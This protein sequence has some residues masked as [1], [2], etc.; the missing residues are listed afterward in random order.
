LIRAELSM[1]FEGHFP[2]L[3]RKATCRINTLCAIAQEVSRELLT[4]EAWVRAQGIPRRVRGGQSGTGIGAVGGNDRVN[5]AYFIW[6]PYSLHLFLEAW[7]CHVVTFLVD[8]L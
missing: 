5:Y 6:A 1:P 4:A 7:A 2:L 3:W 8:F